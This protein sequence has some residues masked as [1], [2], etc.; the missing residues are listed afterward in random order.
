VISQFL[1]RARARAPPPLLYLLP[2]P[3][4][5]PHA[6]N[7][8]S[9]RLLNP[10]LGIRSPVK[11]RRGRTF[12]DG[13][14]WSIDENYQ[15]AATDL[16]RH[17]LNFPFVPNWNERSCKRL[18]QRSAIGC[19]CCN[20]QSERSRRRVFFALAASARDRFA[21]RNA[22]Y[23]SVETTNPPWLRRTDRPTDGL[24]GRL[25]TRVP[26]STKVRALRQ[27]CKW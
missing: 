17:G 4:T 19:N 24:L 25:C 9:T 18:S 11:F 16:N 10:T 15:P 1:A 14:T 23:R 5:Q 22:R 8:R 7:S 12:R 6:Q 26:A 21:K 27:L 20:F 13:F 2:S 3:R